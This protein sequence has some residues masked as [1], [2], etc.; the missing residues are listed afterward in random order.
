MKIAILIAALV[1]SPPQDSVT[2]E[3][4]YNRARD[5]YPGMQKVELQNR[6]HK[7]KKE[8][9]QN[10]L[11]PQLNVEGE[12]TYQSDVPEVGLSLPGGGGGTP[13]VPKDQYSL[14]ARLQQV[15]YQGGKTRTEQR[16][17]KTEAEM[18]REQVEISFHQRRELVEDTYFSILMLQK[19]KATTQWIIKELDARLEKVS[20]LVEDGALL[21]GEAYLLEAE[22]ISAEQNLEEI[23]GNINSA[24]QT[25]N[26]LTGASWSS[27]TK[28]SLP[29]PP[30]VGE[31]KRGQQRATYELLSLEKRKLDQRKDLLQA[32]KA[33]QVSVFG[34]AALGRPGLNFFDDSITP[35]YIVGVRA[36]WSFWN[37]VDAGKEQEQMNLRKSQINKERATFAQQQGIA[38]QRFRQKMQTNKT[39]IEKDEQRIKLR[40]KR[41]EQSKSRLEDGMI[42]SS[43]YVDDLYAVYRAKLQ[44]KRHKIDLL[45]NKINYLT[46]LGIQWY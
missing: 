25:L 7:L 31:Y 45:Q 33:P 30:P 6:I 34:T 8:A 5:H 3:S 19:Q 39:L 28:L 12:A 36:Q 4:C 27:E 10:D 14:Q 42:T 23:K 17:S 22:R 41:A 18:T 24:Y 32:R 29:D 35:Y 43:D 40:Q 9:L 20:A 16:I 21:A 37:M 38:L 1:W 2:L 13:T 11:Y 26:T 44:Q 15:V 46:E